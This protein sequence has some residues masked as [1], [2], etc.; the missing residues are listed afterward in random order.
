LAI[1]PVTDPDATLDDMYP[2]TVDANGDPV[3]RGLPNGW[4]GPI[5]DLD[6][7][8]SDNRMAATPPGG[9]K[10]RAY[11]LTLTLNHVGDP[12]GYPTIGSVDRVWTQDG[13][14][15]G[16]GKLDINGEAGAEYARQLAE[17]MTNRVS[18][19]DVEVV[20]EYRMLGPDGNYFAEPLG[21]WTE[22]A[23]AALPEG[24][25]AI[26]TFAD[27]VL[28]GLAAVPIPAYSK[29]AIEPVWDYEVSSVLPEDA[30]VANV[31]L[32]SD[33]LAE[34]IAALG[35]FAPLG[36][37]VAENAENRLSE[38]EKA[39]NSPENAVFDLQ[40][41]LNDPQ[42]DALVAALP[43]GGQVFTRKYFEYPG[44]DGPT[45]MTVTEDGH[46]YGHVRLNGT[47][48]QY[49]GGAGKG[50]R[51]IEPPASKCNYAKF[52][53]HGAKMDDGDTLAVGALTFGDGHVSRGGLEASRAHYDNVATVAAK[54]TA[55][56]D[57]WGDWVSGEVVDAYRANA[58]DLLL[59]PLSGHWEPDSDNHNHLEMLA[60]HIV[61]TPG[62][63]V[64]RIVASFDA[65]ENVTSIILTEDFTQVVINEEDS[66]VASTRAEVAKAMA[67]IKRA[68][69]LGKQI[70]VDMD[71][72]HAAEKARLAR[73]AEAQAIIDADGRA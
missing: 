42:I 67:D 31:R 51:C 7:P 63:S 14:L 4:R 2:A 61:V 54:V 58:Y 69:E 38:L 52:R 26:L 59:S 47:C 12:T 45:P 70:G 57:Q 55:G 33:Q 30:I 9:A 5:C 44:F 73:L 17:G 3:D 49:G 10:T 18:I 66:I 1:A 21:G 68:E 28:A 19:D 16:E 39:E 34:I 6:V 56:R 41:A 22:E 20:A 32:N 64:P 36:A 46:I 15:M 27:W 13:V 37:Q 35:Q 24:T 72:H 48:F 50:P 8:T 53:V 62:Y 60:A 71:A 29:A 11:P 43:V 40:N 25:R 23:V 65:D